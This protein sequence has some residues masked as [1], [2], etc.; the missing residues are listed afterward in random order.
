MSA[1][2]PSDVRGAD[3]S[4]GADWLTEREMS[5]LRTIRSD[6]APALASATHA[7]MRTIEAGGVARRQ[8]ERVPMCECARVCEQSVDVLS[9]GAHLPERF[10]SLQRGFTAG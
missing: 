4:D 10:D 6:E 1:R 8:F 9:A 2:A 7:L 3:P 5:L